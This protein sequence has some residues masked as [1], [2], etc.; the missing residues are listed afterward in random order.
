M[1]TTDAFQSQ[2]FPPSPPLYFLFSFTFHLSSRTLKQCLSAQRRHLA[3]PVRTLLHTLSALTLCTYSPTI[4]PSS[5]APLRSQLLEVM[6]MYL[7]SPSGSS[8]GAQP[9]PPSR[10]S[11]FL[12]F[13]FSF[14]SAPFCSQRSSGGTAVHITSP[15]L[16][17]RLDDSIRLAPTILVSAIGHCRDNP[18]ANPPDI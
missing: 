10:Q 13:P 2:S 17:P 5:P 1:N 3:A 18:V 12:S 7:R 16:F 6:Y 14:T 15:A 11:R 4:H 8:R 9:P